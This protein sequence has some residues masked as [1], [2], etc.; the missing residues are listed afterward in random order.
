MTITL[1]TENIV[2]DDERLK[3]IQD[4][5][6]EFEQ[7]NDI[8]ESSLDIRNHLNEFIFKKYS[9]HIANVSLMAEAQNRLNK[10]ISYCSINFRNKLSA[11]VELFDLINPDPL[12]N[13]GG[14]KYPEIV[15]IF[16]NLRRILDECNTA[17]TEAITK[18]DKQDIEKLLKALENQFSYIHLRNNL[19]DLTNRHFKIDTDPGEHPFSTML[20]N[21]KAAKD[22]IDA[23]P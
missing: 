8:S 23:T 17:V 6:N 15:S 20:E 2:V 19:K 18:N 13:T 10:I 12:C 14:K 1:D 11:I 3:L 4:A 21:L 7:T 9:D 5:L 16:T 22:V